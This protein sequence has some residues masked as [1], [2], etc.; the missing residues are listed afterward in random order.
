MTSQTAADKHRSNKMARE[1]LHERAN[2]QFDIHEQKPLNAFL[3]SHTSFVP[4]L[5]ERL[6]DIYKGQAVYIKK[7]ES[8]HSY[9]HVLHDLAK[10]PTFTS[11]E[12]TWIQNHSKEM[13][14]GMTNSQQK[15]GLLRD[16]RKLLLA[17]VSYTSPLDTV[18][19]NYFH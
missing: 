12:Q 7:Y 1:R 6:A 18:S 14:E 16:E 13:E 2:L 8:Y 19:S 10:R 5:K 15:F 11:D 9:L 4:F 17:R 3:I